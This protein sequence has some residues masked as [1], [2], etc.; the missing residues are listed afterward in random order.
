MRICWKKLFLTR[1]SGWNI[2]EKKYSFKMELK[3]DLVYLWVNGNDPKWLKKQQRYLNKSIDING[4]YEDNQELKYSLRSVDQHLPWIRKIFIVTDDQIPEFLDTKNPKIQIIDHKD[5]LPETI[6]PT[7]NTSVLEYF[8]HKIPDLSEHFLY[9]NDDMFVNANL[10]PSFFFEKGIPI[11]RMKYNP[12][13]RIKTTL[14]KKLNMKINNH[15]LAVENAYTIFNKKFRHFYPI[16]SHHNID[17]FLKSNYKTVVEDVFNEELAATFHHR[18]RNKTN[19]QRIL[20]SYYSLFKKAG[21]LKYIGGKESC[22]IRV[23]KTDY[24]KYLQKY[25]P[26]LF[27]LNDTEFATDEHRAQIAPF[28][29]ALFPNKS[30]FEK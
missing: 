10:T 18:F 23:H 14:K 30:S 26:K 17:A 11:I 19:I 1:I 20:I 27:C 21:I 9:A 4:R 12:L 3:I 25:T 13:I 22:Q 5:L 24:G 16:S 29:N 6:L 15:R 28:L 7:F 2:R 8:I